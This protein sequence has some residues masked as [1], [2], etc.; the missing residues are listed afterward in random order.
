MTAVDVLR[1]MLKDKPNGDRG[2]KGS[3]PFAEVTS[4][5]IMEVVALV[6]EPDRIVNDLRAGNENHAPEVLVYC[7]ADDLHHLLEKAAP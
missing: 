5:V 7:Y 1:E 3:K 2:P 6:K 4:G